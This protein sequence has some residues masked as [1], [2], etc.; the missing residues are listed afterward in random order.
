MKAFLMEPIFSARLY[1][2]QSRDFSTTEFGARVFLRIAILA[3]ISI[4]DIC[5]GPTYASV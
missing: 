1:R 4:I 5:Q 2:P 3:K